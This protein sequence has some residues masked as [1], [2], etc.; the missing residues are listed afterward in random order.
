[1]VR[2]LKLG[3]MY[4][5][6]RSEI[7][8]SLKNAYQFIVD[9]FGYNVIDE[10]SSPLL[11]YVRYEN[12]NIARII[13]ISIDIREADFG[14][15]IWKSLDGW[16]KDEDMLEFKEYLNKKNLDKISSL[17]HGVFDLNIIEEINQKNALLLKQYGSELIAG[18]DY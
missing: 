18:K 5:L 11:Y 4:N 17:P 3:L 12:K 1:M 2:L 9:D 8:G 16:T 6:N 14:I 15:T 7:I 10:E 13:S